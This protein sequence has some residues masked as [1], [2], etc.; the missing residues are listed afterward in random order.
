MNCIELSIEK[1]SDECT[2]WAKI[3]KKDFQPDLIVYIAKGGFL[4]GKAFQEEFKCHMIGVDAMR[5]GN[6]LKEL[7]TPILS[8]L[9]KH[10]LNLARK[11]EVKSGIHNKHSERAVVFRSDYNDIDKNAVR[12]ILIVDDSVDTGHS[13]KAVTETVVEQYPLATVKLAA[14]NVWKQSES[15]I[16][17][18]YF[19][20]VDTI[21]RTPMSK[22]S[23][24]YKTFL[25]LFHA[26]EQKAI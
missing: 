16:K 6:K 17:C 7:L 10:L 11:I 23:K 18:D 4:I 26:Y 22:D 12:N 5:K 2:K 3:I 14:L 8:N 1:L 9:P 19:K 15:V 13:L 20:Y 24:E 25:E 21:L